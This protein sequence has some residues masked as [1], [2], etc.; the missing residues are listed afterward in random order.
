MHT[1]HMFYK[2][3][4]AAKPVTTLFTLPRV[5]LLVPL[6]VSCE[7]GLVGELLVAVLAGVGHDAAMD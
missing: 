2:L 6:G 5:G 4:Q 3:S 7:D 1:F